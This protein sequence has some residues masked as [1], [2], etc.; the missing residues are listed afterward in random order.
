MTDRRRV[1]FLLAHQDDEMFAAPRML[2]ESRGGAEV[3]CL[4]LTDGASR[5]VSSSIR[6]AESRRVLNRLGVADAAIGFIGSREAIPDGRLV[7]H[8]DRAHEEVAKHLAGIRFDTVF[9][10]AWEGGHQDHD[11]AQLL[12]L[13]FATERG[14][15]DR[16]WEIPAYHATRTLFRVF[17]PLR[18][19]PA[20]F[21]RIRL[22]D[23]L[24][25]IA[26]VRHYRS[27]WT[28]WVGLLPGYMLRVALLRRAAAVP[29]EPLRVRMRPHQ[30]TLL[31]ERRFGFSYER[32][33]AAAASFIARFL[34]RG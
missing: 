9:C 15:A 22:G 27:Q 34:P 11:A 21:E 10:L 31:Y 6:D 29:V 19:R 7:E 28:S 32:F 8:L 12:A 18:R 23:A 25:I 33:A 4:F 17:A 3:H 20:V 26:L 1:L 2:Q 14:I 5:G 16:L 13:A 24:R 30:G